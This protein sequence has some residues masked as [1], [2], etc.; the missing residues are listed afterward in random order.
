M[1]TLLEEM[2]NYRDVI[3]ENYDKEPKP[4]M[5]ASIYGSP[6]ASNEEEEPEEVSIADQY[7]K[8]NKKYEKARKGLYEFMKENIKA[9]RTEKG[10][11]PKETEDSEESEETKKSE[12][13][14]ESGE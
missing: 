1:K 8:I 2:T 9:L 4:D 6:E 5:S 14:K 13:S 12:E 7:A 11:S 10:K 3:K